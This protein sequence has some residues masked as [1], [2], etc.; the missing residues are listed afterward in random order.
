ML[1]ASSAAGTMA[2]LAPK[3]IA[4]IAVIVA[5]AGGTAAVRHSDP[6]P[7]S[8][9]PADTRPAPAKSPPQSPSSV[10]D[11]AVRTP[12]PIARDQDFPV[13]VTEHPVGSQRSKARTR[14]HVFD[15]RAP[16]KSEQAGRG[17]Q[18]PARGR[19]ATPRE[20][21]VNAV[22]PRGRSRRPPVSRPATPKAP[23][24]GS[25]TVRRR[26]P[27]PRPAT[28]NGRRERRRPG[29]SRRAGG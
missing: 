10:V 23:A 8:H 7:P 14:A 24:P 11:T 19:A 27:N 21:P 22:G 4:T 20:H 6:V 26:T 29:P 1:S 2:A 16:R 17:G 3:A 18:P 9:R 5:A 15:R 12:A 28:G 25:S 13:K